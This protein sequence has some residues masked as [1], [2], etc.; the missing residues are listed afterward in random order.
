MTQFKDN[1]F[2]IGYCSMVLH[3]MPDR[4]PMNIL[5]ELSRVC[6]YVVVLDWTSPIPWNKAGVR[7]RRIEFM[8]GPTHF[9]GFRHFVALGGMKAHVDA[10]RKYRQGIEVV[11]TK[12]VDSEN[13]EL[14]ILD[15]RNAMRRSKL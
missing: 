4:V 10:L 3:D 11:F 1:H 2:D 8:V 7:N 6:K 13:E 9:A 14:Y 12:K 5:C 15:T